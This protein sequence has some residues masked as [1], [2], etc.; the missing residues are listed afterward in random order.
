MPSHNQTEELS[1]RRIGIAFWEGY[2]GVAPS[3]LSA[4]EHLASAGYSVHVVARDR[5]AEFP[6]IPEFDSGRVRMTVLRPAVPGGGGMAG[7]IFRRALDPIDRLRFIWLCRSLA[8]REG[9]VA[10]IGVDIVGMLAASTA[11]RRT[12]APVIHWSLELDDP[13]GGLDPLRRLA[14]IWGRRFQKRAAIT[15]VQDPIR[16]AALQAALGAGGGQYRH[17][18]NSTSGPPVRLDDNV[19]HR[20]FNLPAHQRVILHAGMI[21]A[22]HLSDE[23]ARCAANWPSD[24]NLVLHERELRQ[25]D[26]P[27]LKA[28][29]ASGGDRVRLSLEPVPYDR[30][31]RL[32]AS[33]H[34]CLVLYSAAMGDNV[35][36]IGHASGK[37]AHSLKVGVP[38]VCTDSPGLA[39]LVQDTRCG[40]VVSDLSQV[41]GAIR[42]ILEDYEGFRDRAM[43]CYRDR[44]EFGTAFRRVLVDLEALWR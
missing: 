18:P 37:L 39:E 41:E 19:F 28:I 27:Y 26:H 10:W 24:W 21:G 31:D 36:L 14:A 22:E 6:A 2:L 38:V 44:L 4:I 7:R 33:A 23:L 11:A 13:R 42:Q 17:V 32:F 35:R 12:S 29:A 34:V 40:V 3:L 8:G 9:C 16:G 30:L 43:S 15:I 25:A 5:A 1:Q 20:M